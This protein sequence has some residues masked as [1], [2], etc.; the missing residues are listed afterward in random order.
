MSSQSATQ[1][2]DHEEQARDMGRLGSGGVRGA[3]EGLG[4]GVP[5]AEVPLTAGALQ[6]D[7]CPGAVCLLHASFPQVLPFV[8]T[9]S[10]L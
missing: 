10:G 6:V 3:G 5:V 8:C 9:L 2:G 4:Q 7:V 1:Q